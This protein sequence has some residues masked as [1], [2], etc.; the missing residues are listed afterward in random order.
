MITGSSGKIALTPSE[1]QRL[2][3]D[4]NSENQSYFSKISSQPISRKAKAKI[5]KNAKEMLEYLMPEIKSLNANQADMIALRNA[6]ELSAQRI[7]KRDL[8][9]IGI[10]LKGSMGSLVGAAPGA[11]LG[12]TLGLLDTPTV[13]ARLSRILHKLENRGIKFTPK[14]SMIRAALF[15]SNKQIGHAGG[16]EEFSKTIPIDKYKNLTEE[17]LQKILGEK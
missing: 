10:P 14:S 8:M 5:A 13:K 2:K 6:I 12:V 11:A 7:R 1:V 16:Y 17:D 4:I 9:G 15:Q 3:I